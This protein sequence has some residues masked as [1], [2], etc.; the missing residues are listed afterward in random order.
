MNFEKSKPLYSAY[1]PLGKDQ[2]ISV[3]LWSSHLQLQRRVKTENGWKTEQ[4]I[5][6]AR[7][8]LEKLF[9]RLPALFELMKEERRNNYDK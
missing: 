6:L 8:I 4:E 5:S 3:S 9:I 2:G 7:P 1:W